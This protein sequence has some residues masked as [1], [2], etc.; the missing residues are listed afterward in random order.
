MKKFSRGFIDGYENLANYDNKLAMLET[1]ENY[2]KDYLLGGRIKIIHNIMLNRDPHDDLS[3]ENFEENN[4]KT[5]ELLW[6]LT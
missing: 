6:T 3:I 2:G 4:N 5:I 1:H